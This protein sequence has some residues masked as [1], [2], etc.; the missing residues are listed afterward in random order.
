MT[1]VTRDPIYKLKGQRLMSP[2][3]L[4]LRRKMRRIFRRGRPTNLKTWFR[5]G[6][7]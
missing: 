2:G 6:V 1:L 4:I 5:D 3:R 7:R